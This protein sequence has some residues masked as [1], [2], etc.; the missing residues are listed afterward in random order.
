MC[1]RRGG[2]LA[3][4]SAIAERVVCLS[5]PVALGHPWLPVGGGGG[6]SPTAPGGRSPVVAHVHCNGCR[7]EHGTVGTFL[8]LPSLSPSPSQLRKSNKHVT[9]RDRHIV[10]RPCSDAHCAVVPQSEINATHYPFVKTSL[11]P[12]QHRSQMTF[13]KI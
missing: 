3:T 11:N 12:K 2:A 9:T 4:V 7:S 13:S 1:G 10:R 8:S 6:G 5:P